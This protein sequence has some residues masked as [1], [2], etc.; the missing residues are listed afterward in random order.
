MDTQQLI[1]KN[2]QG[3]GYKNI[4]PKT[5]TESVL[6]KESG[7][8][9]DSILQKF[10]FMYLPYTGS[11][12]NTRLLVPK[13]LRRRGL[14]IAYIR[15]DNTLVVEYYTAT[16]INDESWKLDEN[17]APYNIAEIDA[18]ILNPDDL[19]MEL[20]KLSIA[21]RTYNPSN[22]SGKGYK[23]LRRNL[24]TVDNVTKNVLTQDMINES[25]TIYEIRYDFDLNGSTITIPEGCT[26]KFD[27]GSL[28]NGV[29]SGK[30]NNTI[31]TSNIKSIDLLSNL[32][33]NKIILDSEVIVDRNIKFKSPIE[34]QYGGKI[35]CS[36]EYYVEFD[37]FT[38]GLFYCLDIDGNTR[39]LNVEKIYPQWFGECGKIDDDSTI[40]VKRALWACR[41]SATGAGI[42]KLDSTKGCNTVYF[43]KGL[44][45]VKS[46]CSMFMGTRIEGE[47]PIALGYSTIVQENND[48]SAIYIHNKNYELDNTVLNRSNGE[49]T[50]YNIKLSSLSGNNDEGE[51][52]VKYL[53]NQ[54][55]FDYFSG[56]VVNDSVLENNFN[57]CHY[58]NCWFQNACYS[59]IGADSN[60]EFKANVYLHNCTFDVC[61]KFM[62]FKNKSSLDLTAYD[63]HFYKAY[64][65]GIMLLGD[66]NYKVSLYNCDIVSAGQVI[67]TNNERAY[68]INISNDNENSDILLLGCNFKSLEDNYGA[69]VNLKGK[70]VTINSCSFVGLDAPNYI[71]TL[72][73]KAKENISI[74]NNQLIFSNTK[75]DSSNNRIITLGEY[76][77][78]I[79]SNNIF[80][81]SSSEYSIEFCVQS[82]IDAPYPKECIFSNNIL[83]GIISQSLGNRIIATV[84]N[85]NN[86]GQSRE[87]YR[88]GGGVSYSVGD[89]F[90]T[91]NSDDD[92][93]HPL[94]TFI[95]SSNGKKSYFGYPIFQEGFDIGITSTRPVFPEG[96][97]RRGHKFFNALTNKIEWWNGSKWI[98]SFGNSA[99]SLFAGPTSSR[100]LDVKAGFHYYDSNLNLDIIYDGEKWVSSNGNPALLIKGT[101]QQRPAL[102]S[103]NEG[104]EY[105]DSTLKK[106][107]LWNGTAW[108]NLD[109]TPLA[110]TASNTETL[111]IGHI[112]EVPANEDKTS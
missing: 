12:Q 1:K 64:F 27:G 84:L 81:N 59:A 40:A 25:N 51:P 97:E 88:Y 5:Y 49:V 86:T 87:I 17:W 53:S 45:I 4:Y 79:I 52:I 16:A 109:G 103:T 33:C 32:E 34:V 36:S 46:P 37:G 110:D 30:V 74:I 8:V 68:S 90:Y 69:V 99:D 10:N 78:F 47:N 101:T 19:S 28:S 106:K 89:R 13:K 73:V 55:T 102:E 85:S 67:S 80:I 93:Y 75:Q 38:C 22:F 21:D 104:F 91:N 56:T 35:K 112:E 14:W 2:N 54:Q 61:T 20:G 111:S 3:S 82:D 39:F 72:Y 42:N 94:G 71:K 15:Y 100:P 60:T 9:L 48:N 77:R 92:E 76:K 65:G 107:I 43:P 24:Q 98:D 66:A 18:R 11:S 23:I 63:T 58:F 105:Y 41:S 44:Y 31:H 26:L 6:D 57:D 70:N 83:S 95:T 7:E 108:V 50:F 62:S 96:E 29:L